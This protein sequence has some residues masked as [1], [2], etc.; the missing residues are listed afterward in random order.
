MCKAKKN[1]TTKHSTSIG[2]GYN[3]LFHRQLFLVRKSNS[4][5][6]QNE[7]KPFT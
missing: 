5:Q 7:T 3:H 1:Y 6:Q 2:I 4:R